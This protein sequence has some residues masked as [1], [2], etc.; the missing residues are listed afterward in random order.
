MVLLNHLDHGV[1]QMPQQRI[2]RATL[3]K[4]LKL[5]DIINERK[6]SEG[7]KK[8]SVPDLIHEIV[9]V[10]EQQSQNVRNND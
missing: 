7:L 3:I 10:F 2:H 4:L 1:L 9:C 5:K 8:I 6:D